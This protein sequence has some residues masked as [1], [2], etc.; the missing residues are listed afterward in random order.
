MKSS[1][2]GASRRAHEI[3]LVTCVRE[4]LVLSFY[5]WDLF[6][7]SVASNTKQNWR[8][9]HAATTSFEDSEQRWVHPGPC[10]NSPPAI[11]NLDAFFEHRTV[12]AFLVPF[13]VLLATFFFLALVCR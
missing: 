2:N 1:D 6:A 4:S 10:A 11:K 13:L 12:V 8:C 7:R 3:N 5:D 9:G